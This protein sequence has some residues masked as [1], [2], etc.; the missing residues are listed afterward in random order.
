MNS[1]LH[2][3]NFTWR[4]VGDFKQCA[5][6]DSSRMVIYLIHE[7]DYESAEKQVDE[8]IKNQDIAKCLIER[9]DELRKMLESNGDTDLQ[10]EYEVL[11]KIIGRKLPDDYERL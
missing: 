7:G 3:F 4:S 6:Y 5:D 2:K 1:Y 9:I 11:H 10:L 8:I